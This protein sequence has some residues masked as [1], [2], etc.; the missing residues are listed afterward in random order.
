MS[1]LPNR[2]KRER[3]TMKVMI[4]IYCRAHHHA[5]TIPCTECRSFLAYAMKR[6]EKCPFQADKPTCAQCSIHCYKA[7][8]RE[9]VRQV[10]QYSGPRML[11]YHPILAIWHF[12]DKL[13]VNSKTNE[14]VVDK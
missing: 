4:D 12:I 14:K 2:L 8:M 9:Q 13:T 10:M 3:Q 7:D 6:I 1:I 11:I 5:H